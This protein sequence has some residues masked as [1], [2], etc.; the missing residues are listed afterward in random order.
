MQHK[1][2]ILYAIMDYACKNTDKMTFYRFDFM[3]IA[4]RRRESPNS[5]IFL[6]LLH[7]CILI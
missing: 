2:A 6:H 1:L 3:R 4:I 5:V 7:D